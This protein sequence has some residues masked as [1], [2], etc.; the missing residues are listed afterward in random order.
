V[1]SKIVRRKFYLFL[2]IILFLLHNLL[3][4]IL[5]KSWSL[6]FFE[7]MNLT[8]VNRG[9]LVWRYFLKFSMHYWNKEKNIIILGFKSHSG[10]ATHLRI[11]LSRNHSRSSSILKDSR[12]FL[13]ASTLEL[14]SFSDLFHFKIKITF[15]P[16]ET[17]KNSLMSRN[18]SWCSS[19]LKN[20]R[21]FLRASTLELSS[22]HLDFRKHLKIF[23]SPVITPGPP[24]SWGIPGSSCAH[25]T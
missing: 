16:R 19:I 10:F 24:Q 13:R 18:H 21:L 17:S 23:L 5:V 15:R 14:S 6:S 7:V 25:R 20:S 2:S 12:L 8:L 22:S 9:S 4:G 11:F 1:R 3:H